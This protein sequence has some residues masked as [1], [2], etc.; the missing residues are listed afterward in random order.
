LVAGVDEAGRG[1]LAGPVV[2]AAVILPDPQKF[3]LPEGIDDSKAL[4]PAR[5]DEIFAGLRGTTTI[6]VGVASVD[7]IDTLNIL[8]ATM[9]AMTRAVRAMDQIPGLA[10]VDGNHLPDLPCP[11]DAII[12]GDG[13]CLSI[14]AASIVAKVIRDRI[15]EGLARANPSYGWE[16]NRGY[17]TSEHLGAIKSVGVTCHH[18]R[19]FA[20]VREAIEAREKTSYSLV[21]A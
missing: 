1:P 18:R 10:L 21:S 16:R 7:E 20:P 12:G 8:Q 14:A 2:A 13:L 9:L 19:S 11:G 17:G 6:G 5:R 15:M 3:A 4:T